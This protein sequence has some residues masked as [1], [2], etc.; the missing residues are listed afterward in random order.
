MMR[1]SFESPLN[2]DNTLNDWDLAG[3][4]IPARNF[5]VLTPMVANRTGQ[6]WHKDP[7][8]TGNFEV[9]F[10]FIVSGPDFSTSQGFAFWYAMEDYVTVYPK[11]EEEQKLWSLFGYKQNFKGL[12]IFFSNFDNSNKWNPSISVAYSDGAKNYIFTQD[13]PTKDAF[14]FRWRNT[15]TPLRFR[16]AVGPKGISGQ[17]QV[18]PAAN[19]PYIDVF[20][21]SDIRLQP[22]GFIG[23][24]GFT[25]VEEGSPNHQGDKVMIYG[26]HM[27]NLDMS[28]PGE[29]TTIMHET[30]GDADAGD[31]LR[32]HSHYKDKHEQTEAL[33]Q[34]T[35]LLYKHISEAG[36]R[37]QTIHK[38]LNSLQ[39]QVHKLIS[40]VKELRKEFQ[41]ATG[42]NHTE[43]I[44]T[45]KSELM[46]LRTM[47]SKHSQ[48]HSSTLS[49]L[50]RTVA[51]LNTDRSAGE[52]SPHIRELAE[53]AKTLETHIKSHAT[54]SSFMVFGIIAVVG[55]VAILMWR[56][57]RALEKR[58]FL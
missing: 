2:F 51:N 27:Y 11:S 49:T 10:D 24:T 55:V 50:H 23:F 56:R 8:K 25:G 36:P 21:K 1:H 39:A 33:R 13:V 47:F 34:L 54:R 28:T 4:S 31:I 45:M 20:R 16:L 19:P 12:G 17:I 46:G 48:Q 41:T 22:N 30:L 37:E 35:R 26:L 52:E 6:F 53:R 44:H 15:P 9:I 40:D 3:A 7:V 43:T 57:M 14:Y 5:V 32:D 18:N 38:T 58:H 42:V 29:D